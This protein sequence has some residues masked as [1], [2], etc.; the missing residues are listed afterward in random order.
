MFYKVVEKLLATLLLICLVS[1]S[2]FVFHT[3]PLYGAEAAPMAETALLIIDGGEEN[4]ANEQPGGHPVSD[5]A[6][7]SCHSDTDAQVELPSGETF[8]VPS[9]L[10]LIGT[11][12]TADKSIALLDIALRRRFVFEPRYPEYE[13]DGY[14][15]FD[16]DVLRKLNEK[17]RQLKGHDFQ[18]GHSYF[19]NGNISLI[20]RMNKK[21]IPLLLEYFM[22]DEKEVKGILEAAGLTVK[23]NTWPLEISE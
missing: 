1:L 23:P 10:Y 4:Q 15:I 8:I 9:N 20:E 11:M 6:C 17:I 2:I 16:V 21:I 13:I 3:L 12:N 7:V 14:P 18:I 5:D 22:N 19:M